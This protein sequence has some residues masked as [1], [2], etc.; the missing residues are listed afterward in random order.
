[1]QEHHELAE[2]GGSLPAGAAAASNHGPQQAAVCEG[3]VCQDAGQWR[4]TPHGTNRL[5]E[6]QADSPEPDWARFVLT[7]LYEPLAVTCPTCCTTQTGHWLRPILSCSQ[8]HRH[9]PLRES[10]AVVPHSPTS[11]ALEAPAAGGSAPTVFRVKVHPAHRISSRANGAAGAALG[12][13]G[14]RTRRWLSRSA[15]F[16]ALLGL[17]GLGAFAALRRPT[18]APTPA[19]VHQI[20]VDQFGYRPDAEK[21]VIFCWPQQGQFSDLPAFDP[22]SEFE[23]RRETDHQVIF[24]GPVRPWKAGATDSLSGD[25][26]W[27]GDFSAVTAPGRYYVSLPGGS[28]PAARSYDF[29]IAED[30]YAPVLK[31]S[32]RMFFYQRCGMDLLDRHGGHWSHWACHCKARQDLS[33]R[34]WDGDKGRPGG[35]PRALHGGW[36]DAGDYSKYVEYVYGAL[37]DLMHAA[38]WYPRAFSDATNIPESGNGVPD[39]LDEVKYELDW[40]LRMQLADGSVL[41]KVGVTDYTPDDQSPPNKSS[42]PRFYTGPSTGATATVAA[43][44]ALG[45]RVFRPYSA[46]YP[47]YSARLQAAAERAW[48]FLAAHPEHIRYADGGMGTPIKGP[49]GAVLIEG[50]GSSNSNA[51]TAQERQLRVAAAAELFALT[52]KVMYRTY[53]DT[54]YDSAES[55]EDGHQPIRSKEF[56]VGSSAWIQRGLVSYGLAPQATPA[57]VSAIKTALKNGIERHLMAKA[58][59]DPYRAYM[60][61]DLYNWSSHLRKA[62]AGVL[63]L[64]GVKL[65]VAPE[66]RAAY[67]A[68]AE[69]YLHYFHGRNPL[70]V[71]YLTNMGPKGAD[72]GAKK[73]IMRIYHSWFREKTPLYDGLESKYGPAPGFVVGG[74]NAFYKGTAEPP[75]GEPPMKAFVDWNSREDGDNAWEINEPQLVVQAAYTFLLASTCSREAERR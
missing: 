27:H 56:T 53:F 14:G 23:V 37:W 73:S 9:F 10:P 39:I 18:A 58:D 16:L 19:V 1:V 5:K 64:W 40:L 28:N 38:E 42:C 50:E 48:G 75:K 57:V 3:L 25:K 61:R 67:L 4:L 54:H 34:L 22:G 11:S 49:N 26:V 69:E 52:G 2:A 15:V 72:A 65:G 17:A 51:T 71:V 59:A 68:R 29:R 30:V 70:N 33:A 20:I 13:A 63:A 7:R 74:P 62:N 66:R 31:A 8:C 21:F 60:D 55:M 44:A 36:H 35:D 46:Q 24:A 6:L 47:G 12:R 45:A 32:A 41:G 43:V